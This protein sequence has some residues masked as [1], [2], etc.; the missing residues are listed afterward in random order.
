MSHMQTGKTLGTERGL[1]RARTGIQFPWPKPKQLSPGWGHISPAQNSSKSMVCR[2]PRS[3][4]RRE[5]HPLTTNQVAEV[6]FSLA[7]LAFRLDSRTTG[8]SRVTGG[9]KIYP[10]RA[11]AP[12]TNLLVPPLPEEVKYSA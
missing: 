2:A 11:S 7:L 9:A 1:N 5:R 6:R 10:F 3:K 8:N 12:R 4:A